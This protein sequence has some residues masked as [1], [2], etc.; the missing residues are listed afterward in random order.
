VTEPTLD[1]V[2]A[3]CA[4]RCRKMDAPL[5]E[6]L[7]AFAADV[8][9]VSPDFADAVERMVVRLK[10]AG[11]GSDAPK[12]GEQMPDFM[13][14]DETGR[15]RTLDEFIDKGPAVI[16]FHR[17]HWC[18]YCVINATALAGVHAAIRSFGAE[19]IAITPE[20]EKFNSE[21]KAVSNARFPVLSDIDNGYAML[22]NLAFYVGDEK[23]ERMTAAGWDISPYNASQAWTLPIPATF[24]VA[25]GGAI[26]ARF[27]DPDYRRRMDVEKMLAALS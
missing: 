25:K 8:R 4:E 6:R 14:P 2:L 15:L 11:A 7:A 10:E 22:L 24:V 9:R 20:V 3:D 23:R 17:G 18:P 12:P 16:A 5:R 27:I 19:L 21:L 1:Q 26:K 13:L